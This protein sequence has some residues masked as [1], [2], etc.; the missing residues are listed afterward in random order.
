M[1]KKTQNVS[2]LLFDEEALLPSG[3]D[4]LALLRKNSFHRYST[5]EDEDAPPIYEEKV[6]GWV[7]Y[8]DIT[9]VELKDVPVELGEFLIFG[10]RTDT[11]KV[12][13]SLLK[14]ELDLAVKKELKETQRPFVPRL[15][16]TELKEQILLRLRAKI[17]PVPKIINAV[18]DYSKRKLY[19]FTV[20]T[21]D[22]EDF[23]KSFGITFNI[24]PQE[25]IDD[26][27][28]QFDF[29]DFLKWLWFISENKKNF[30]CY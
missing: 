23:Q 30:W 17:L 18:W 29:H 15:R 16:K 12:P 22:I 10:L 25:W 19:L 5:P 21:S 1:L 24:Q 3:E 14:K 9:D 6:S 28:V 7:G 20:S 13:P 4:I 2:L 11:R 26:L 8:D 27:D